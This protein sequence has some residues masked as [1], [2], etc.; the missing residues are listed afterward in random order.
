[1]AIVKKKCVDCGKVF[2][3]DDSQPFARLRLCVPCRV[4]RENNASYEDGDFDD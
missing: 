2:D 4:V 3:A 1:M